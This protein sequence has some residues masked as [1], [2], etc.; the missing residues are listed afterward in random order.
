MLGHRGCRL[1]ITFP[2]IYEMQVRR[3][4]KPRGSRKTGDAGCN[5]RGHDP[6][7][8]TVK[9]LTITRAMVQR[10]R[11]DVVKR[12]GAKVP[13]IIGT[14]IEIPR[15]AIIAD[16]LSPVSTFSRFGTNDLTQMTF[17]FLAER[18]RNVPA[19]LS[20]Y[21]CAASVIHSSRSTSRSGKSGPHGDGA[22]TQS[23]SETEGRRLW[24]AWGRG[25]LDSFL[26]LSR[27]RLRLLLAVPR[28]DR[29]PRRRPGRARILRL[30][31]L[32]PH[33]PV[34][35]RASAR[36]LWCVGG[37]MQSIK[38]PAHPNTADPSLTLG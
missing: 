4:S 34:S 37:T 5:A 9:E 15:A 36:D 26:P 10:W 22:G 3:S 14:M 12:T 19:G 16:Q 25:G 23:K 35:S 18:H 7:G 1:G 33:L 30:G 21:G 31:S 13:I 2:E 24:R 8:R 6:A 28:P 32:A 29:A 38:G 11:E 20:E 27:T 17:G